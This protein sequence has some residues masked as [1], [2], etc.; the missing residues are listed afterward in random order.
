MSLPNKEIAA[1]GRA[2]AGSKISRRKIENS[3]VYLPM[4]VAEALH[5]YLK[6][7][8]DKAYSKYYRNL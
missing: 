8:K 4:E 2:I 3:Y 1:L 7:I 6:P 5:A